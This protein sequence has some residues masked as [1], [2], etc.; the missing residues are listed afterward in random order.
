MRLTKLK[1]DFNII[2]NYRWFERYANEK[3][4]LRVVEI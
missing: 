2:N 3:W 4:R 1:V